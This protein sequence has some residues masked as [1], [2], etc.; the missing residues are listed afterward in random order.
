MCVP[1]RIML[2][3]IIKRID[4]KKLL[5][6]LPLFA[7]STFWVSAQMFSFSKLT[8]PYVP[9]TGATELYKDEVWED[10]SIFDYLEH[11]E[12]IINLPFN[13]QYGDFNLDSIVIYFEGM[14]ALVDDGG[15]GPL[16]EVDGASGHPSLIL[17]PTIIDLT[18]REISASGNFS[19]ISYKTD[20]NLGSRIFKMEYKNVGLY[21]E[22]AELSTTNDYLSF[23]TWIHE[24]SN[25]IEY[26]YGPKNIS[27]NQYI[28]TNNIGI[29]AGSFFF[30]TILNGISVGGGSG[31][32]SP[33][34]VNDTAFEGYLGSGAYSGLPMEGTVYRF[35][36]AS[37]G[38]SK[39]SLVPTN[40][41]VSPNPINS[42]SAL[43]INSKEKFEDFEIYNLIGNKV[44][45]GKVENNK[46]Q[47]G[48][49]EQGNYFITLSNRRTSATEKFVVQ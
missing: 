25:V 46:I 32:E 45:S 47:L 22:D 18:D 7:L 27:N 3:N 39:N 34:Y 31:N 12:Y 14:L 40:F 1:K 19:T 30:D 24:G 9:L 35:A 20:G 41:V 13:Y 48:N 28:D 29:Y 16:L 17:S 43:K 33:I 6:T 21:E 36:P 8:E 38:F 5:F 44:A 2:K 11:P 26:R 10:P 4:M 15:V 49:F 37:L 23:Q 42:N